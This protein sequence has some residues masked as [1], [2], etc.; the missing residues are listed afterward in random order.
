MDFG[1]ALGVLHHVPDTAG[2]I[3]ACVDKLRPGAPLLL[4]LYYAFDNRPA[5]FRHLWKISDVLR[6]S[7]AVMPFVIKYPITEMLAVLVYLPLARLARWCERRGADVSNFPLAGYRH[8]SYYSMRTDCL[9]RFGT[10]LEKRFRKQEI[11]AMMSAAGL[12]KLEFR[13]APPYWCVVGFKV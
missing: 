2:A 3:R 11:A 1:Y 6:R 13:D 8:K 4:Y 12:T 10:R 7:L 5:W 9:D